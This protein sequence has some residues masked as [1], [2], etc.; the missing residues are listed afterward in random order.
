MKHKLYMPGTLN[1]GAP[2]FLHTTST[3]YSLGIYNQIYNLNKNI[4]LIYKNI[5]HLTDPY[6]GHDKKFDPEEYMD[7]DL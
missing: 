3:G 2:R 1:K 6:Y 7:I 5:K 4:S